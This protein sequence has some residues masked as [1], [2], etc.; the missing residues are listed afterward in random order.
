ML[1]LY[2]NLVE[3]E[4]ERAVSSI[5]RELME[6]DVLG[7]AAKRKME[8]DDDQIKRQLR[9]PA[10]TMEARHQQ[11]RVSNFSP[12]LHWRCEIVTEGRT[13]PRVRESHPVFTAVTDCS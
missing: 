12:R 5:L 6:R 11:V 8:Q 10:A 1:D 7:D 4:E 3:E 13:H 9:D 2:Y